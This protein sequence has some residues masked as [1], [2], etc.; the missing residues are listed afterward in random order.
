MKIIKETL[1]KIER[2]KLI[3]GQV[4]FPLKT[5]TKFLMEVKPMDEAIVKA[6]KLLAARIT[7]DVKSDDALRYTQAALNLEHVLAVKANIEQQKK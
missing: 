2:E 7:S 6:I 5:D 3:I 4:G 1:K